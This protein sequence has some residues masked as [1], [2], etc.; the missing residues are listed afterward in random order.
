MVHKKS[1][2]SSDV[3]LGWWM[4]TGRCLS[5]KI[6]LLYKDFFS[7]ATTILVFCLIPFDC[8][9]QGEWL[10]QSVTSMKG[11]IAEKVFSSEGILVGEVLKFISVNESL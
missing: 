10:Q 3:G 7:S 9:E 2:I 1:C 11:F 4:E 8:Q 6:F 5:L